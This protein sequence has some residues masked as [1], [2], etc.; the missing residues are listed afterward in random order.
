MS[1][2]NYYAS[3]GKLGRQSE[4]HVDHPGDDFCHLDYVSD[5]GDKCRLKIWRARGVL[6]SVDS[7]M[8][9]CKN[10]DGFIIVFDLTKRDSFEDVSSWLDGIRLHKDLST[11]P[12]VL[13]GTRLDLCNSDDQNGDDRRMVPRGLV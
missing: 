7:T 2:L 13:I 3:K 5:C 10:V 6:N 8:G 4:Q 9:F 11:F 1:L 12:F